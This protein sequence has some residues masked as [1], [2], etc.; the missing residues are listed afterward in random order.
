MNILTSHNITTTG[1]LI[2]FE[3]SSL[4]LQLVGIFNSIKRYKQYKHYIIVNRL[5]SARLCW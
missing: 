5:Q 4:M 1:S 2:E 3:W